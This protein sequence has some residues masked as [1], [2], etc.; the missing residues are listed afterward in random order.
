MKK[1]YFDG[2]NFMNKFVNDMSVN[3]FNTFNGLNK[4]SSYNSN[5]SKNINQTNFF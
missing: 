5:Y 1:C 3:T 2:E 4:N